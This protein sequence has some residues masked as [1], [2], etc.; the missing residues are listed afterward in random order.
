LLLACAGLF[1]CSPRPVAVTEH[2]GA[3]I[4]LA[5]SP[6]GRLLTAGTKSTPRNWW[7]GRLMVWEVGS[8]KERLNLPQEHWVNA[9]AFSPDGKLLAVALGRYNDTGNRNYEGYRTVPGEVRIYDVATWKLKVTLEHAY[10]VFALAFSPDGK[11][12]ASAGGERWWSPIEE[13]SDAEAFLW[14]TRTW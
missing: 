11:L 1:G 8:Y 13:P 3:A 7:K 12:L 6:D 9:V 10:G 2:E 14:D 5:F 4:A